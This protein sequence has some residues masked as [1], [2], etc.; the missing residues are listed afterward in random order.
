M[1]RWFKRFYLSGLFACMALAACTKA[2]FNGSQGATAQSS[3]VAS[4][5]VPVVG[6]APSPTPSPLGLNPGGPTGP[7]TVGCPIGQYAAIDPTAYQGNLDFACLTTSRISV[8]LSGALILHLIGIGG[9]NI[10]GAGNLYSV[11]LT[12]DISL[13][14]VDQQQWLLQSTQSLIS[15]H[16]LTPAPLI[17]VSESL[18]FLAGEGEFNLGQVEAILI[19]RPGSSLANDYYTVS[20]GNGFVSVVNGIRNTAFTLPLW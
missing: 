10:L 1:H 13:L 7:G 11:D 20:V 17:P 5:T 2:N 15:I 6:P 16:S 8:A 18:T 4:P 14:S 9:L 3:S 12:L 19:E